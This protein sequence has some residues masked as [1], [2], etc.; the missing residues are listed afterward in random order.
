MILW[1]RILEKTV[2]MAHVN[3]MW[4]GLA[5][6]ACLSRVVLSYREEQSKTAWLSCLVA[7]LECFSHL[8][9]VWAAWSFL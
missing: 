8:R 4:Y 1:I 2:K 3:S 5:R 6:A 9:A 7:Q